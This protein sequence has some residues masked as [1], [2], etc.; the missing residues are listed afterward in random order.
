MN[1]GSLRYR[2]TIQAIDKTPTTAGETADVWSDIATV[3]ASIDPLD[4]R[5]LWIAK[6]QQATET[7]KITMRYRDDITAEMRG[8]CNGTTYHFTSV[9]AKRTM[10]LTIMATVVA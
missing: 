2:L 6:Q 10:H 8:V 1:A 3:W 5:E 7:H 9:V 4:G